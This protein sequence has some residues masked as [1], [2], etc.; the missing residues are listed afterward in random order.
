MPLRLY[1][2]LGREK[3]PFRTVTPGLVRMYV[4]GVTPY[5]VTH[6]GHAFSYVQ[7]DTLR[8]YL[9]WQGYN[10]RYVQNITDIDDDMIMVSKRQGG[11]PIAEIRDEND[12]IFRNDLDHLNVLRPTVYPRATD[13][14]PEIIETTRRIIENGC[15]YEVDGDVFFEAARFARYGRLNGVTLEELA[16][17]ENPESKR[18]YK[19]RGPLDFLLWQQVDPGDPSWDSP[20]G[21]GRPGWSIECTAMSS[22]HLG[23]QIDI[24]GGGSDLIFPHHENEIAQAECAFQAE[25]FCG[26]WMH[27]GMLQLE[28]VKMS[29]SLGNLVLARNLM[30]EYEP[31]HLRLYL[32]STQIR[33]DA[34]YRGDALPAVKERFERLRLASVRGE[35]AASAGNPVRAAF[36]E[37]MDDDFG[38]PTALDLLDEAASRVLAGTGETDDA[39]AIRESLGVMGFAFAGARGPA[40]GDFNP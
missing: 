4:C 14:I 3:R 31:D 23:P 32:L 11:R 15:G 25:P 12:A 38:T 19:K 21:L 2:S 35:G 40:N 17:R 8:R 9:L 28:G 29:K 16:K 10:V 18:E 7:F 26:W 6:L 5:D 20:W 37:A 22:T 24:H 1:S 36:V 27:N 33:V 39:E 13:H 30:K 34:D